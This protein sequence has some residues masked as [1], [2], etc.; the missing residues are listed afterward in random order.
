[1]KKQLIITFSVM[2]FLLTASII[3]VLYAEGYRFGLNQGKIE[4]SSTGML[5]ATSTPDGAQVFIDGH[6][7]TATN[8]TINLLPGEYKVRIAKEGYFSW[9]KKIKIQKEVVAK[10]QA[11]LFPIA[12]KLESITSIGVQT[13]TL[14]PSGTR[15]A[16]TVASQSAAKNGIYILD[17][18]S[19]PILTLQSASTQI[20]NDTTDFF[21][22]A[23]LTWSPDGSQLLATISASNN[24]TT[25]L[26]NANEFNQTPQDITATLDTTINRWKKEKEEKNNSRISTLPKDLKHI[27]LSDF[28][29]MQWSPDETKILYQASR[30]ANLPPVITPPLIGTDPTPQERQIQKGSIYVYDMKEDK[31]FKIPNISPNPHLMWFTDSR[32]LIY[33]EKGAINIMDYDGT[34]MTTIYAGPFIDS[35]VFPWPDGSKI[36]ILTNLGNSNTSPNLYTIGLK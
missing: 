28:R 5:V 32:H 11:R 23:S 17:M 29:I 35:F 36:V 26:L 25:Y 14:D 27:I 30:S 33:V 12:P 24:P 10:A 7:T 19:R 20:V 4:L 6:L 9:K 31:N 21:S 1:M 15:I 2:V 16:Y 34:N 22:K 3:A 13:P 18:T 8:N